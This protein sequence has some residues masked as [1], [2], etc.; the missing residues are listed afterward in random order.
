MFQWHYAVAVLSLGFVTGAL[1]SR[2]LLVKCAVTVL[3]FAS[4]F[5]PAWGAVTVIE[6][7]VG[8]LI[9]NS[10]FGRRKRPNEEKASSP[11]KPQPPQSPQPDKRLLQTAQPVQVVT[12]RV[13]STIKCNKCQHVKSLDD[14][15]LKLLIQRR[16]SSTEGASASTTDRP[17][18]VD[19][20]AMKCTRCGAKAASVSY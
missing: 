10:I 6:L 19:A 18:R 7:A 13:G 5:G 20:N 11:E 8:F 2:S 15:D 16:A 3:A 9:G 4:A 17:L 14:R 1:T 12:V